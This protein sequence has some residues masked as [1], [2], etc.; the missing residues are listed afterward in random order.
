MNK[1]KF[2]KASTG[3]SKQKE[4]KKK[5]SDYT[6]EELDAMEP[7]KEADL[8]AEAILDALN[9]PENHDKTS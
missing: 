2:Q 8:Q 6:A 7:D 9:N 3:D 1:E 5:Y 4:I